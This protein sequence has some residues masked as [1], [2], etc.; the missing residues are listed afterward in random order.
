MSDFLLLNSCAVIYAELA[1]FMSKN[2]L[3]HFLNKL[4]YRLNIEQANITG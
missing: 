3:T 4:L 1:C 2:K